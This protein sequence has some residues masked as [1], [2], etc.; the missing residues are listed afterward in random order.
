MGYYIRGSW[1]ITEMVIWPSLWTR[2]CGVASTLR[3]LW[4]RVL[5]ILISMYQTWYSDKRSIWLDIWTQTTFW[6]L[7][8]EVQVIILKLQQECIPVGYVPSVAVAISPAMHAPCYTCPLPCMPSYH[9]CPPAMHAPLPC[10]LQP[11][12]PPHHIYPLPCMPH[13]PCH[14]RLPASHAPLHHACPLHHANP[15][16]PRGQNDRRL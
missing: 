9:A 2:Y 3:T 16:Y 10:T 4:L 5:W 14:T 6:F 7:T 12:M 8:V 13:T 1:H 11:C 15:L